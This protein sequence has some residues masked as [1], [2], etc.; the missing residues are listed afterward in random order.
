MVCQQARSS[1]ALYHSLSVATERLDP[2]L[3]WKQVNAILSSVGG[4]RLDAAALVVDASARLQG[5][6]W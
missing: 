6:P 2:V 4:M 5:T 1:L 3:G